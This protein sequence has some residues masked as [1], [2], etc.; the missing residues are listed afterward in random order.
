MKGLLHQIPL[1]ERHHLTSQ[2]QF[3]FFLSTAHIHLESIIQRLFSEQK[4]FEVAVFWDR[5]SFKSTE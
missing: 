5:E 3:F 2:K 1:Q 4:G